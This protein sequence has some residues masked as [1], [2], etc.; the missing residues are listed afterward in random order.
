MKTRLP[1]VVLR[2]M[3]LLPLGQLKL[4]ISNDN[5]KKIITNSS[6]EYDNYVLLVS[7]E[8]VTEEN[9]KIEDLPN[10]GT[11]GKI[12]SSFEL[13]N[14]NVRISIDGINRA[15]IFE[16]IDEDKNNLSAIIGPV[17][18]V[19]NDPITEEAILRKLK[20]EF[21]SYVSI[22]PNIS[23]SIISK[24][25]DEESLEKLTD[26]I[27]NILPIRFELKFKYLIEFDASK[28]ANKLIE[29]I[30]KEKNINFV[31]RVIEEKLKNDLDK[32][33]KDYILK[34]KIKII[35]QELGED[36]SKEDE[37]EELQNKISNLKCKDNIKEKLY[38]EVKK[39]EYIPQTSPEIS[40]VKNYIDTM[41]S[42][43]YEIY[44][45]DNTNLNS[46]EKILNS[47]HYGLEKVKLRILEYIC[48]KQLTN[49]NNSPIICLVGPPGVGKTSLAY[50]ISKA[51]K[52]NFIKTSVGGVSDEAE[53]IG[54][55][56]TYIGSQEGRIIN[57]IKKAKSSNPVF[58]IDE[59]DKM[60]KDIKGDPASALLEVLDP[61]Q[62]TEFY[63][64][65]IE[66]AYDLS[67]V[68]FI[69]TANSYQ[70]IPYA[71]RDRLEIIELPSYTTIEKVNIV[72]NHMF[73]VLLKKHG[74]TRN[75]LIIDDDMIRYIIQFYTMEAGVRDL[76]RNISKIMR[77]VAMDIV[78]TNK[79]KKHIITKDNIRDY[80]GVEKY[81]D[82]KNYNNISGTV[83]GLAYT[84]VGGRIL[85]IEV[86]YYKGKG[87]IILTGSLGEVMV[88]SAKIALGYIKSK[89][90]EFNIDEKKLSNNDIH[91]NAID[92]AIKKDGPSAGVALTTAIISSLT[93]YLVPNDIAMTGEITLTG[94]INPIGG[95]REKLVGALN[96]SIKKVF[97]PIDN[98]RDV[99]EIEDEIKNNLDIIYVSNYIEIYN[100]IFCNK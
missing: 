92:G 55:R 81:I 87:D 41:L 37:I 89:F 25:S 82:T 12:T 85:P 53:I 40:I 71:L 15:N 60:T 35:R 18:V 44:T 96:A 90:K 4:E 99:I 24:I 22:M 93:N 69:L 63:D 58:L 9:L 14:G 84:S 88:E 68:M 11:I 54:H 98:K 65:Y 3:I 26:I 16:Y 2:N 83:N 8:L 36:T 61:S 77:K 80:L 75:N 39:Y 19:K 64:N 59:I 10:T 32:T 21:I 51:L 79:R 46:I 94:S 13:P 20:R 95:L 29:D 73:Q 74:L 6:S 1:V 76:E 48:V 27:I 23:D 45:K 50:S 33:N 86:T 17:M 72:K 56:R 42:L 28:R 47:T 62:N 31:E 49:S 38:K 97:V 57:G 43:P 34:E 7:P 66:E 100:N 78:K 52:R 70:D 30:E 67:K 91:I 5:D